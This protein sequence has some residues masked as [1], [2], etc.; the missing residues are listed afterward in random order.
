MMCDRWL[1]GDAEQS[2]HSFFSK[3]DTRGRSIYVWMQVDG[4]PDQADS[5]QGARKAKKKI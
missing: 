5:R 3:I 4:S 1:H 2:V